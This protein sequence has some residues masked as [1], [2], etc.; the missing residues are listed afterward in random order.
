MVLRKYSERL[1][2]FDM[3]TKRLLLSFRS[4][5]DQEIIANIHCLS[6]LKLSFSYIESDLF[7]HYFS[8]CGYLKKPDFIVFA[9]LIQNGVTISGEARALFSKLYLENKSFMDINDDVF[10]ITKVINR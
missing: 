10:Q 7:F 2:E 5:D 3:L 1:A 6:G 4:Q 8:C 9:L